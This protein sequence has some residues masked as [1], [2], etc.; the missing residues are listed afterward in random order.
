M[1]KEAG[2]MNGSKYC[3]IYVWMDVLVNEWMNGQM[4]GCIGGSMGGWMEG[5]LGRNCCD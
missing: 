2:C 5:C 3:R 4:D 1:E